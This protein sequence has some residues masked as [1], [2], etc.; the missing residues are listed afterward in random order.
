MFDQTPLNR[1]SGMNWGDE[2]PDNDMSDMHDGRGVRRL[3]AD[4]SELA[5]LQVRL[6]ASDA[7]CL[8]ASLIKPAV[9]GAVG[10]AI[11]LGSVPILVLA[12]AD[13]LVQQLAW[14]RPLAELAA[15]GVAVLIAVV[16]V[17]MAA[18]GLRRCGPPLRSSLSEFEKNM[19]T[20]REMLTGKNALAQHWENLERRGRAK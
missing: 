10:L 11:L 4:I 18:A 8:L 19:D 16:F 9:L 12:G 2:Q 15:A 1:L 3:L 14:S 17:G 6:L 20:L 7:R 5:E 13:A